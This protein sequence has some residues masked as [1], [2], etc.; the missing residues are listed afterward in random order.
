MCLSETGLC[1]VPPQRHCCLTLY[2]TVQLQPVIPMYTVPINLTPIIQLDT[3]TRNPPE[4]SLSDALPAAWSLHWW[5][6]VADEACHLVQPWWRDV[7][8]RYWWSLPSHS[9]F[10]WLCLRLFVVAASSYL[11]QFC[12]FPLFS[13][14]SRLFGLSNHKSEWELSVVDKSVPTLRGF[15]KNTRKHPLTVCVAFCP[16]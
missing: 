11:L 16:S 7:Q 12:D 10:P 13:F 1:N 2:A 15:S 4:K 8:R 9:F 6:F 5:P 3:F 14:L